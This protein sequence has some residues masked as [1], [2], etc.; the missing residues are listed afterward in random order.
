MRC[1]IFAMTQVATQRIR[2]ITASFVATKN[3]VFV[4]CLAPPPL[5]RAMTSKTAAGTPSKAKKMSNRQPARRPL[6]PAKIDFQPELGW[7]LGWIGP[8]DNE[9][10]SSAAFRR[11]SNAILVLNQ[12]PLLFHPVAPV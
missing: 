8:V 10:V 7:E 3:G 4:I 9:G 12:C 2:K 5:A 6:C 11:F 1:S